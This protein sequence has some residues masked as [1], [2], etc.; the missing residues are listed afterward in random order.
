M[1]ENVEDGGLLEEGVKPGSHPLNNVEA[2]L[3]ASATSDDRSEGPSRKIGRNVLRDLPP[4]NVV[5]FHITNLK[6]REF[7]FQGI[8]ERS[9]DPLRP[10]DSEQRCW[11]D[12]RRRRGP[13]SCFPRCGIPSLPVRGSIN[14]F[15][16]SSTSSI[17]PRT[18]VHEVSEVTIQGVLCLR[19]I[20]KTSHPPT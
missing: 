5:T 11:R 10:R 4:P 6:L 1:R 2:H 18:F 16:P 15:P 8:H 13:V 14:S 12:E 19:C 17:L 3:S 7:G 9:D 20:I